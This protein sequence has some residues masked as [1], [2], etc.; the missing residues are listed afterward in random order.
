MGHQTGQQATDVSKN[1]VLER[2]KEVPKSHFRTFWPIGLLMEGLEITASL[3]TKGRHQRLYSL[4]N[5][6]SDHSLV[7]PRFWDIIQR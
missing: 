3:N 5:R 2:Q 1:E 4:T 6:M 7:E